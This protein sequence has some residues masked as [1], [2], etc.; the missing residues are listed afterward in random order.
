MS[1]QR[2]VVA[3]SILLYAAVATDAQQPVVYREI[4]P[5]NDIIGTIDLA[6]AG[7]QSHRGNTATQVTLNTV[8]IAPLNGSPTNVPPV[9]SNPSNPGQALGYVLEASATT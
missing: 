4:F 8:V 9:N 6:D 2:A 5:R 7:W 3:L 1:P